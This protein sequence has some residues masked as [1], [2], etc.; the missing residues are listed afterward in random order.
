MEHVTS[1][2]EQLRASPGWPAMLAIAHTAAYDSALTVH[3]EIPADGL[4][5]LSLPVLVL[6]EGASFPWIGETA[7]RVAAAGPGGAFVTLPG[8]PHSP[9]P[10]VL[11]P[12]LL[13]FFLA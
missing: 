13:R 10:D 8:Q 6:R 11:A 4:A 2:D 12:E 3:S 1:A 7:S 9:A 5:T